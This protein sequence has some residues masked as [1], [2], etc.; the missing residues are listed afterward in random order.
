MASDNTQLRI[1]RSDAVARPENLL[2]GGC[3]SPSVHG[4]FRMR[5]VESFFGVMFIDRH[6]GAIG[7]G[8]VCNQGAI[9]FLEHR[10]DGLKDWIIRLQV[11]TGVGS[12][13]HADVLPDLDRD[14]A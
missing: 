2:L 1:S 8:K 11:T 13:R 4:P 10:V 9:L 7:L 12:K 5:T 3:V 14:G 6:P